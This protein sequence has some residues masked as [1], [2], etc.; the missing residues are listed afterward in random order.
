MA[1]DAPSTNRFAP[2]Y[3][4]RAVIMDVN[5]ST[6]TC[7]LSTVTSAKTFRDVQWASP[8]HHHLQGEGIHYMPEVGAHCFVASPVDGSPSFVLCFV[9]PP[10]TKTA[11]GDAPM[12]STGDPAGS[13]TDVTYQSNRLDL[14]PG[15]IALT[16]RDENF[17]ILRRGGVVQLGATPLAQRIFIPIRNFIRDY[18]ENYELATPAGEVSWIIDRPEFD[19]AGRAPCSWS[20]HLR[21]YATD[22]NATVRVRHL[23][24]A[25]AGGKKTAWEVQVAPNGVDAEGGTVTGATYSMLL[26]TDGTQTEMIGASREVTVKGNDTLTVEGA[27]AMT[28]HGPVTL[29]GQ[30]LALS[31]SGSA[32]LDGAQ[33]KLGGE[34]ATHPAVLGDMLVQW[35][36]GALVMTRQGPAP[37]SPASIAQLSRILSQKVQLK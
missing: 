31:A 13:P 35:L 28:A 14:N 9:A 5:R 24:L 17:L 33:V 37:F 8:Y 2:F 19:P 18:A 26:L 29:E 27:L 23:P 15:D 4:E 30:A 36:S 16:T 22:K 10:A 25:D 1:R 12:R 11:T 6:W 3:C 21:E 20:F 32:V 34:D 7:T